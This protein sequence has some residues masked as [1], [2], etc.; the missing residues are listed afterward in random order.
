MKAS[1]KIKKIK[2]ILVED[3]G[4]AAKE[5]FPPAEGWHPG[6]MTGWSLVRHK[7]NSPAPACI[8][9]K[10]IWFVTQQENRY[11]MRLGI[12]TTATPDGVV[13]KNSIAFF[14]SKEYYSLFYD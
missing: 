5:N 7:K 2:G 8:F 1:A 9:L 14:S 11:A 4:G 6:G 13:P 10:R 12:P 3:G